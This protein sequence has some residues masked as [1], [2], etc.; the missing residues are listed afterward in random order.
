MTRATWNPLASRRAGAA[1]LTLTCLAFAFP[2]QADE[3]WIVPSSF[4]TEF[5]GGMEWVNLSETTAYFSPTPAA[6]NDFS[7]TDDEFTRWF[8]EAVIG[9]ADPDGLSLPDPFGQ[10][11]RVELRMRYS[12]G[13]SDNQDTSL[14]NLGMV[15]PDL[16]VF[17]TFPNRNTLRA[18]TN[19]SLQTWD[20]AAMYET[21]VVLDPVLVFTPSAGIVYSRLDLANDFKIVSTSPTRPTTTAELND[22]I[23][24]HYYGVAVG[25]EF[26][27]RPADWFRFDIGTRVDLMGATANLDASQD[28]NFNTVNF[29]ESD[30]DTNFAPRVTGTAGIHLSWQY[31]SLGIEGQARYVGYLPLADHPTSTTDRASNIDGDDLWSIGA[32]GRLTIWWP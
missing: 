9:Y 15:S 21:D 3:R 13:D 20:V 2:A 19:T 7:H 25:A 8:A 31:V 24:A 30:N 17:T 1:A 12:E 11:A 5:A 27:L 28:F 14:N 10:N 29:T 18:L 32:M 26:S 16:T 23:T 22:E 4:Y 6:G